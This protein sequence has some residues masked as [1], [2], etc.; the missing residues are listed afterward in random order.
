MERTNANLDKLNKD[1]EKLIAELK[2][3]LNEIKTL[4]GIVP[5]CAHCKRIRNDEGFWEQVEEYVR[6]HTY[7]QFSHS[8]CP[9]CRA[10]VYPDLTDRSNKEK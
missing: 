6:D 1:N 8:I 3:S 7:A 5:I 4:Q 9:Q 2:D 10:E